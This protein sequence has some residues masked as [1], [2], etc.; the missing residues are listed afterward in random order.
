MKKVPLTNNFA[1]DYDSVI[2]E[3]SF[4]NSARANF[5]Y[6][7]LLLNPQSFRFEMGVRRKSDGTYELLEVSVVNN[8]NVTIDED[9][10]NTLS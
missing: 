4:A 9:G 2:G 10:T 8:H 1:G 3:I 5:I 7:M 6:E